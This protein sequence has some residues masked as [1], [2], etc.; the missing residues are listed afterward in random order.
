MTYSSSVALLEV[1]YL[2]DR[3]ATLVNTTSL[4]GAGKNARLESSGAPCFRKPHAFFPMGIEAL[5]VGIVSDT[6]IM[7]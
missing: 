4:Y 7:S 1:C 5:V 3:M 2:G 6:C